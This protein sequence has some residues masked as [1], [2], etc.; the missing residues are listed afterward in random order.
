M[1]TSNFYLN[2]V[3]H[4]LPEFAGVYDISTIS[5]VS[6]KHFPCYIVSN[7]SPHGTPGTHWVGLVLYKTNVFYFDSL[8][9]KC[10]SPK[11]KKFMYSLGYKKYD[12][13]KTPIQNILSS[14][15]GYF[16]MA[17][18]FSLSDGETTEQYLSH[19]S[20]DSLSNDKISKTIVLKHYRK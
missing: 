19:F 8:G 2:A 7:L 6:F 16:V 20:G 18:F 1:A 5:Q 9:S 15:C 11:I 13:L 10:R 14:H 4:S 12:Y 17:Y 3:L